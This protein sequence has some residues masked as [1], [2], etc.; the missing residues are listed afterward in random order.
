MTPV[1]PVLSLLWWP[2]YAFPYKQV[3][4]C[5]L[6]IFNSNEMLCSFMRFP[7][8]IEPKT[9]LK[10]CN[11]QTCFFFVRSFWN[12]DGVIILPLIDKSVCYISWQSP[13][14]AIWGVICILASMFVWRFVCLS[15]WKIT[16]N[17]RRLS[18]VITKIHS[19]IHHGLLHIHVVFQYQKSNN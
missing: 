7:T 6:N 13:I 15:G 9:L 18:L 2:V 8:H 5:K 3:I 14:N 17:L 10:L 4:I 12:N 1:N 16:H 11:S 19:W